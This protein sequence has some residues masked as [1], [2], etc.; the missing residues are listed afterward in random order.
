MPPH[1]PQVVRTICP[2]TLTLQLNPGI[3]GTRHLLQYGTSL[4]MGDFVF[5]LIRL[6]R[7]T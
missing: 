3:R 4:G 6:E 1:S 5:P 7:S 2:S